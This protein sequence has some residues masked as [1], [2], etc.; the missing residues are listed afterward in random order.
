[1]TLKE[2]DRALSIASE[3]RP[4]T[5]GSSGEPARSLKRKAD[6]IEQGSNRSPTDAWFF[7]SEIENDLRDIDLPERVIGETLACAWEYTRC[8]IP[9]YTNWD[10]YV[11]FVRIIVIGIIAEF[12]GALVDVSSGDDILGYDLKELLDTVF[13]GTPAHEEMAREYRTFLLITADKCSSRRDSEL[14]RR[15]VNALAQ[16]PKQWFRLR[17][18]DALVRFTIAAA[19]ACNDFDK[20]WFNEDELQIL[21]ELGDTLYDAVAF[22]KHRAEG[23]TNS[24]FAYVDDE[25]RT[26]SFRRCREVLWALDI[27][28]ARSPTHRCVLNF[29][30]PFGGP[31]HMMMRRYRFVEDGLAIGKPETEYVIHQTRQNFKLWNRIDVTEKYVQ[32]ARY[33][34]ALARGD[35]LMF[36]G[37]AE[38]LEGSDTG[39]CVQCR[40]RLSY[41][42][43]SAGQFGGVE[44]C[45]RCR[46]NWKDYVE[47]FP[48]RA[49]KI[50]PVLRSHQDLSNGSKRASKTRQ[51]KIDSAC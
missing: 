36:P 39:T 34:D 45:E 21:A 13:A 15:Y 44:L 40:H 41:G 29:L 6:S 24:T 25:M 3:N 31:I 22:H 42:A 37:L 1:M 4:G 10:R 16:S 23:E 5:N 51:D 9:T 2:N 26:E 14:F 49:V 32:D 20:I 7:P 17:D 46:E 35:R 19:L 28:W 48:E 43:K 27:A 38:I 33:S 18:C 47:A 8:V 12:R 30:R 50:F 11:A